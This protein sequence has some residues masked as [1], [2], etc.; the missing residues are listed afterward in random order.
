MAFRP[1]GHLA[2]RRNDWLNRRRFRWCC[3]PCVDHA[4]PEKS[5]ASP[6]RHNPSHIDTG[7]SRC[8]GQ[9]SG[10][11]DFRFLPGQWAGAILDLRFLTQPVLLTFDTNWPPLA[12]FREA[13]TPVRRGR[14]EVRST[15]KNR[16]KQWRK[17]MEV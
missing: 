15:E 13:K 1:F 2:G 17:I 16:R 10:Q 3:H 14:L 8:R 12:P 4:P 9:S 5:L 11:R 7:K 6:S